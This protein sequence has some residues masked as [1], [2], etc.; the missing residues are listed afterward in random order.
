MTNNKLF[1]T[2]DV[3]YFY[4]SILAGLLTAHQININ[5]ILWIITGCL[6]LVFFVFFFKKSTR[7][8]LE[9]PSKKAARLALLLA[10]FCI[11]ASRATFQKSSAQNPFSNLITIS[12]N[13]TISITGYI[14]RPPDVKTNRTYLRVEANPIHQGSVTQMKGTVLAIS[15][16]ADHNFSYGDQVRLTGKISIINTENLSSYQKYLDSQDIDALMYSPAVETIAH[17]QGSRF[18]DG[19]YKIRKALLERVYQLYPAPENALIAGIILGDESKIA[20]DVEEDFQKTGTA[21]IIAISGANFAI[22]TWLLL[23]L[24]K[25]LFHRWW[26]PLVIIP[27]IFLYVLMTGSKSA[28]FRAAIMCSITIIGMTIGRSKSGV[29]SLLFSVC[30]IGMANPKSLL[31]ISLQLSVMATLGILLFKNPL[32]SF[33]DHLFL[34]IRK[35]P[36]ATRSFITNFVEEML[37]ISFS[38]Q[39]FTIWISAAAFHQISVI[40]LF[41][42]FLITPFQS[43]IMLGGILSIAAS[44]IFEPFG[45]LIAGMVWIAPA[46]TIRIVQ[47]CAGLPD[48]SRYIVLTEK[49]AW[50][51]IALILFLWIF[52]K[53][54]FRWEKEKIIE[55]GLLFLFLFSAFVWKKALDQKDQRLKIVYSESSESQQFQIQT[56]AHQK[57]LVASNISNYAAQNLLQERIFDVGTMRVVLFDFSEVWMK[58]SFLMNLEHPPDIIY[59]NGKPAPQKTDLINTV[60]P[61]ITQGFEISTENINLSMPVAYLNRRGWMIAYQDMKIFIP[62]GVSVKTIQKLNREDVIEKTTVIVLGKNDNPEEW[63]N[64]IQNYSCR[65]GICNK[66]PFII[67]SEKNQDL[68]IYSNGFK[69]WL[70]DGKIH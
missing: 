61:K 10:L 11:A 6:S 1:K 17:D 36:D 70:Y 40:S 22:L 63:K 56:P 32:T 66:F 26:S 69:L 7:Y 18:L 29:H 42:N 37:F 55:K 16:R 3:I 48:A 49:S 23:K 13:E 2:S 47:L 38:A 34:R 5:L 59:L 46:Y 35:L 31:D 64:F 68:E 60:L 65:H 44:L 45:A 8:I 24:S 57:I 58:D 19:I 43:M 51:I 54:I 33:L 67:E 52:R 30:L 25:A 15:Y 4:L 21:H 62:M 9:Q 50:L 12:S 41:V 28:I 20:P 39:I 53:N 27:L 14:S